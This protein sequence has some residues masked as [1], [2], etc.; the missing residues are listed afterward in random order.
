MNN[1]K[2]TMM[3]DSEIDSSLDLKFGKCWIDWFRTVKPWNNEIDFDES[4]EKFDEDDEDVKQE[5]D[6]VIDEEF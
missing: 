1:N 3:M 5:E 4:E 6:D 2:P